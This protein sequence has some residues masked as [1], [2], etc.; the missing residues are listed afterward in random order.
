MVPLTTR[1][2]AQPKFEN[3]PNSSVL[4]LYDPTTQGNSF[5]LDGFPS[6]EDG[7]P[8]RQAGTD[9]FSRLLKIIET[10]G[11]IGMTTNQ[12]LFR[13]LMEAG[14]LD[15]RLRIL[16]REGR[17]PHEI[18]QLLY[19]EAATQ[20][21]RAFRPIHARWPWEGRVS[22]EASALLTE[23]EPLV[24]DI[25]RIAQA[26]QGVGA[27]TKIPNLNVG[28][29][30]IQKAVAG[31]VTV[32]PNVTLV[33]S[34][35][36][37]LAT[38]EGYLKGLSQRGT[39]DLGGIYSVNS[40]FVSRIDRMVDPMIDEAL[41]SFDSAQD[42]R[43][44]GE[45]LSLLKG[46]VAVAQAKKIHQI[47]ESIF[48]GVPFE[49]PEGLYADEEGK[50]MVK[51]IERLNGLFSTLKSHGAHPQRLLIA[52][53]GV[54]SGQPYS[55]LL[56]VLPFL[57]PWTA[58]TLPEPTL[59][60]LSRFVSTLSEEEVTSLRGRNLM[61]EPLPRISTATHP[62]SE[63]DRILLMTP[64][65]RQAQGIP[66]ITADRILREVNDLVLQP[67]GTSLREIGDTL[68]DKGASAFTADEQATLQAIQS[69][70]ES[71]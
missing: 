62:V 64:E 60:H 22:Q 66:E 11:A 65:D 47:F 6:L 54:K 68:R 13:Q 7:L 37:Y 16:K 4:R 19:N 27:F 24:R 56:Y 25:Q 46:K 69:K 44:Q 67:Q 1:A 12:T 61:R 52:S 26:M 28:P 58:N 39:K 53:S 41:R 9:W 20:A 45:R 15:E 36:H 43:D 49:D 70:L 59:E 40:L 71:L 31:E 21:A 23:V 3:L 14:A 63:W 17:S 38:V 33:F 48:L 57:G 8:A 35:R 30:A 34:D 10:Q 50:R 18:Y 42:R 5:S 32:H 2:V 29:Q 55:P 51:T